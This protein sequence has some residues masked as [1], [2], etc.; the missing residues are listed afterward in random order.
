MESLETSLD[1]CYYIYF[2]SQLRLLGI[3]LYPNL[4]DKTAEKCY[5]N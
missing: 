3:S 4:L 1:V 2:I 5:Y